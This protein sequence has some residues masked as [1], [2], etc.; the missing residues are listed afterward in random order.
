MSESTF[1]R[2]TLELFD[3]AL[4]TIRISGEMTADE[5]EEAARRLSCARR[6]LDAAIAGLPPE[7]NGGMDVV[8]S[9]PVPA[10][11]GQPGVTG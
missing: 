3:G 8:P 11:T 2:S 1:S 10:V 4:S 6:E 9:G 5:I 7:A